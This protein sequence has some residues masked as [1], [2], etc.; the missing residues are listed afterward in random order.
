ML[1]KLSRPRLFES[2]PRERLFARL[3]DHQHLPVTLIAA[4][5]GAGKTTLVASWLE[6]RKLGGIWYQVDTGDADPATFF[7]FLGLAEQ[8]LPGRARG[9]PPLPPL[10]PE[11]LADLEGFARRFFRELYARLK[12]PAAVVLDNFQEA[13]DEGPLHGVL[14]C[15]IDEVPRG[16]HLF[17]VSRH[18]P[19]DRYARLAANRSMA[20]V[21]WDAL[22][23]TPAETGAL[24][25]SGSVPLDDQVVASLHARSGG[26][27]AGLVLLAEQL[28]RGHAPQSVGDPDS[29]AQVFAYFAGQLFDQA[30][31]GDRRLLVALSFLPS[32]SEAMARELTGDQAAVALLERLYRRHLFTDR[33]QGADRAYTF[34]ALFRAF[35]QHRAE[36]ELTDAERVDLSRRAAHLLVTAGQPEAAMPLYI[37]IG[38]FDA[39]E[40]LVQRDAPGLIG[41]G[42]WK[43]VV[44]WTEA[45]PATRIGE[46]PWLLHWCG[47]ARIGVDPVSARSVLERAHA[48]ASRRGDELCQVLCAAGM[49]DA[50][51]LEYIEFSPIT[52][53]IPALERMFEPGFRFP[54][55]E[56]ELRALGAMLIAA[57]YRAPDH[58]R[59][60]RCAERMYALLTTPID[61]NL[62]VSAGTYLT[63]YG[64]FTGH[65]ELA[66]SASNIVIPLLNDPGVHIFRRIFAWAV[67]CWYATNASDHALGDRAVA[68]NLAIARD[69]GMHLAE[70]FAVVLGYF[71]YMDRRDVDAGRRA[72]DRFAE[73]MIPS[74]PYEAASLV[75]MRSWHGMLTRDRQLSLRNAP[76]AVR[77]FN[78]AGSIPHIMMALNGR[79][80]GLTEDD[81]EAEARRAIAEHRG[82]SMRRNMEWA[83]WAPD[84][85]EAIFALRRGDE[86]TLCDRLR[87]IFAH[88]RD[89]FDQ[90]GHQLNWARTWSTALAAA[91]LERDVETA[92]VRAFIRAFALDP[93]AA[94][95]DAWPWPIR[96]TTLG[97]FVLEVDGQPVSFAGK[98]PRKVLALLKA[99]IAFGGRDVKD[100]LLI[101][102]LWADQEGD[103]ARDAFRV[104]LHRLRKL[105]GRP[106]A[107]VSDDGRVGVDPRVCWVDAIAFE[108][109]LQRAEHA[110]GALGRYCGS[111]LPG[112]VDEPWTAPMRE[113]LRKRFLNA[114]G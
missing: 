23:L 92:H 87:R 63:L 80:W 22:K 52:P 73:I 72:I 18:P 104:A 67:I 40:A 29:L 19:P 61:T 46:N 60:E 100:Y 44:D 28:R 68:A 34:H 108:S 13:G 64:T 109:A 47:T 39:A 56:G 88:D 93:P 111:F 77:H 55:P 110:A 75:N 12:A 78:V 32:A 79:I 65:L 112:D 8:S 81:D 27:A 4:P 21:D 90:Y 35:L 76:D 84:A 38:D 58:P 11:Y 31:A 94:G 89:L 20:L 17:L 6:S 14:L 7:H 83:R 5:P 113:R 105:L 43:V 103:V 45:L 70:R 53:W 50:Y 2:V 9:L 69:E 51:F 71:L 101:D 10:T 15:A 62:R 36:T 33:R 54:D 95:C 66:R 59:V 107:I 74:H 16:V 106:D 91:A 57:T 48:I 30:P 41:Q 82:W 98:A 42:R 26:W 86:A 97:S 1:A 102:A 25:S 85:A 114:T 37:G 49:V 96:I 99:I 3:D 24:V